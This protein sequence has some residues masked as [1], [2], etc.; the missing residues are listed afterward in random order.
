MASSKSQPKPSS[1][2]REEDKDNAMSIDAPA[3]AVDNS[4]DGIKPYTIVFVPRGGQSPAFN[5]HF[6][7]MVALAARS[8]PAET[9]VRLVGFSKACED[10]LSAALGIPRVSSIA[11]CEGAPQAKG[12][13]DYVR[14]KVPPVDVAWLK[15][16]RRGEFLETKIDAIVTK[17]GTKKQRTS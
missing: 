8:Q 2:V 7:Q 14:E 10:R 12:L 3:H 1:E 9:A 15:E 13:V 4:N 6:P 5:S 11:I 17:I 16:A